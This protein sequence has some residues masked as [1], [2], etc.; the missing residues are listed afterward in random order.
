MKPGTGGRRQ[1]ASEARIYRA[2]ACEDEEYECVICGDY[3]KKISYVMT[4][5]P[6]RWSCACG[7]VVIEAQGH[8]LIVSEPLDDRPFLRAWSERR[9]P[10]E[11]EG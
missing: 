8:V 1:M 7:R 3:L 6:R 4:R 2:V 11:Q 5:S 9:A 10:S